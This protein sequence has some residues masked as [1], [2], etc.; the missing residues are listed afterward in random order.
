MTISKR[1]G[2]SIAVAFA[3][4]ALPAAAAAATAR[5]AS[6]TGSGSAC[7][8]VAPCALLEALNVAVGGDDV[9][10]EPGTYEEGPKFLSDQK[11]TLTIHGQ[12]GAPR[13]VIIDTGLTTFL[14]E[15]NTSSLSY[16]E[17]DNPGTGEFGLETL[18]FGETVDRVIVHML[19]SESVACQ[20]VAPV[21]IKN[22]V[23]VVDGP[24]SIALEAKGFISP[25]VRGDTLEANGAGSIGAEAF[26]I[27]G[28]HATIALSNSIVHG[29]GFDLL[30]KADS[31]V[32]SEASIV[33]DH[34]NYATES[35][36]T[37][38]GKVSITQPGTATNQTASPLF[39]N[40]AADDFHELTGSP[41]IA[42]GFNSAV[43]GTLDLDGNPRQF[44]GTADIGAYQFIPGPTCQPVSTSTPFGQAVSIQ[45]QCAGVLGEPVTGFAIASAPAHG[46]AAVSAAGV[47]TYTPAPGYS[48]PDGLAF[49]A[50][51]SH[52][53]GAAATATIA[54][55]PPLPAAGGGALGAPSDSQPVLSPTT[56][57]ALPSGASVIARATKGTTISYTDSQAATTRF[58]VRQVLGKG[59]LSHGKCIKPP[60]GHT[61]GRACTRLKNLGSFT[62]ADTAGANRF[63]FSG[64]VAGHTLKPG[65]YQLLSAPT[66]AAGKTGP[67]HTNT[68]KIVSH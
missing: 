38:G 1:F 33:A 19:G 11:K 14:L 53:T 42:A 10:I 2:L 41:T 64:R 47:L 12:E 20:L 50:I 16:V 39:V 40:A 45:L 3:A 66:N 22:S 8:Q 44:G 13:P 59:L 62:H 51:S 15:A 35:K 29:A 54:V 55:G 31:N 9:T 25:S 46:S 56:F 28:G 61:H 6:P 49:D 63:R 58:L 24:K 17:F 4:L 36:E 18:G 5:F 43:N 60:K 32:G 23:C 57:A 30:A 26:A 67:T 48:G 37:V 65:S 68:F 21:T 7:T 52:G 34:S 27:G